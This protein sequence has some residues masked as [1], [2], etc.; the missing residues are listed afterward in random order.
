LNPARD[1]PASPCIYIMRALN[2]KIKP[3]RANNTKIIREREAMT[4]K[5]RKEMNEYIMNCVL[6]ATDNDAYILFSFIRGME[7]GAKK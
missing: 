6:T 5:E 3:K 7:K 2:K 1:G 4:T